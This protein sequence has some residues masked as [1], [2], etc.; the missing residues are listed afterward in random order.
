MIKNFEDKVSGCTT[1]CM[2]QMQMSSTIQ[3]G[4]VH[5]M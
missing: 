3:N 1:Q 2:Q 5:V 4:Q